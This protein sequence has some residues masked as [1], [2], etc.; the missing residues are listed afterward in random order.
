[1]FASTLGLDRNLFSKKTAPKG[2]R[3]VWG[4]LL[5]TAGWL[6]GGGEPGQQLLTDCTDENIWKPCPKHKP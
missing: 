2:T 3:L 6:A 5:L 1:M 4:T